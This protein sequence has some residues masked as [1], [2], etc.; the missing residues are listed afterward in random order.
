MSAT[1]WPRVGGL[2]KQQRV[3]EGVIVCVYIVEVQ[4]ETVQ[5]RATIIMVDDSEVDYLLTHRAIW[6]VVPY[7]YLA[8]TPGIHGPFEVNAAQ[9]SVVQLVQEV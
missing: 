5:P 9:S 2:K 4:R 7:S 6:D 8:K 1:R 3:V